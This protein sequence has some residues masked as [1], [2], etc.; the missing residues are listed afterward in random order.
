MTAMSQPPVE[1]ADPRHHSH[2]LDSD[3]L[4]LLLNYCMMEIEHELPSSPHTERDIDMSG[5]WSSETLYRRLPKLIEKFQPDHVKH[6]AYE[7][8]LGRH[9]YITGD[10]E[11]KT[12]KRLKKGKAINIPP[13]QYAL[14]LTEE[15]I[16]M[17]HDALGLLSMKSEYKF[18]GLISVS[19]FHIDPGYSGRL[20]YAVYN[21]APRDVPLRQGERMFQVWYAS[22]DQKTEDTYD[23]MRGSAD[24]I[25]SKDIHRVKG[26]AVNPQSL[27]R[28]ILA[29]EEKI[30]WRRQLRNAIVVVVLGLLIGTISDP[31]IDAF[32]EWLQQIGDESSSQ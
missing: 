16:T 20:L 32:G 24:G 31:V 8:C 6:A 11:R 29:L 21:A 26:D 7:L 5:F 13:G 4:A 10:D 22:L 1:S 23:G 25:S 3:G 14:L 30:R 27:G 2:R 12:E 19:G 15:I 17:P 9:V 28:R 18:R